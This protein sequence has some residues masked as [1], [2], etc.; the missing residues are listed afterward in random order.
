MTVTAPKKSYTID[1]L[2]ELSHHADK[3]L[4]LVE[5]ELRQLHLQAMGTA[6]SRGGYSARFFTML[7]A[8]V[9]ATLLRQRQALCC[10]MSLQPCA[11]PTSLTSRANERL[12]YGR[13]TSPASCLTWWR[14][15]IAS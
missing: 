7:K 1:D 15:G 6:M 12:S 5:G 13:V 3:C 4:E 11:L 10:V 8:R 2:W 9:Q 14:G